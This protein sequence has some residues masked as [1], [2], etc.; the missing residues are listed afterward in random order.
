MQKLSIESKEVMK[1]KN[2]VDNETNIVEI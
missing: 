2:Q 1:I